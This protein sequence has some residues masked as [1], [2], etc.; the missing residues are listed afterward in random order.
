MDL[1]V[2]NTFLEV[3]LGKIKANLNRIRG[4]IGEGCE[5]M[6]VLKA[7][8][9]GMGFEGMG[10]FMADECSVRIVAVAQVFEAVKLREAGVDCKILV[11]GGVPYGNVHAAVEHGIHM[12]VFNREFAVLVNDEAKSQGNKVKLHT[13]METGMN[14]IGVKPGRDLDRLVDYL[15]GLAGIEV[16]GVYSHLVESQ[17]ADKSFSHHQHGLFKEALSQL[18]SKGIE[19]RY[20]HLCNSAATVWFKEAHYT[21]VR[22]GRLVY[23]IDPNGDE[24]NGLGLEFPVK[25]Y[26]FVT[27][28]KEIEAG[29][30]V[31]YNRFFKANRSMKVATLSFGYG[32]GYNRNLVLKGGHVLINGKRAK[33]LDMCMDQ[34][35]VD[36]TAIEDVKLNDRAVLLGSDGEE[37][38]NLLDFS[39]MLGEGYMNAMAGIGGRVRRIYR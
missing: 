1:G 2:G 9:A 35:F 13:K 6:P 10:H 39:A 27:N 29:E 15:K 31:G 12:P 14:R 25:W 18:D 4:H 17:A 19:P 36:V 11:M 22:P 30:T 16:V 34:S 8:A 26:A 28:L 24:K 7:N 21:H 33:F 32:D 5:V 23:G 37:E 20:I 38:I 3:D